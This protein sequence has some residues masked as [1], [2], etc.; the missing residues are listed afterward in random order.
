MRWGLD[1]DH[2]IDK[3]LPPEL[4]TL[5]QNSWASGLE[6]LLLGYALPGEAEWQ[7]VLAVPALSGLSAQRIGALADS[8]LVARR[9]TPIR[10]AICASQRYLAEHGAPREPGDLVNHQCIFNSNIAATR[11]WAF[12]DETGA[13]LSIPLQGRLSVNNGDAQRAA[14]VAGAGLVSLPTF[15]VG[16][17]RQTI[18][19][20]EVFRVVDG[21]ITDYPD[22]A[23]TV[24]AAKGVRRVR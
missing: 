20:I 5:E 23:D 4:P 12:V 1:A 22:R 24:L 3:G 21:L 15:I 11:E 16:D 2:R 14:A 8:S 17:E 6:R 18:S 13:P 19:G 10:R 9:I 7:D